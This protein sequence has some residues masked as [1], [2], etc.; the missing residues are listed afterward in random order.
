MTTREVAE[1][2]N[3]ATNTIRENAKKCLPNKRFG[4]GKQTFWTES[5]ITVLLDFMKNNQVKNK[6]LSVNLSKTS[7][8]L[9]PALRIRNAMIEM[10]SAYEEELARIENEKKALQI[11]LDQAKEWFSIKR[12]E[13][14]NP[15]IHFDWRLLK[16][17]TER[18]NKPV[19]KVFDQNY[20]EVNAYHISVYES[21]Y[22]DTLNYK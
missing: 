5:E 21:L 10:Q 7:T 15:G 8:S 12:M 6:Q 19:K 17:E 18:L 22:F 1:Q 2:L 20:G 9:S 3:C 14:L 16:N 13:K 4:N 11:T